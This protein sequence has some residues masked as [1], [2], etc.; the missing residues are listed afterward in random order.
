MKL[1]LGCGNKPAEGYVHHDR[2]KHSPFVDIAFDLEVLPWPVGDDSCEE[3]RAID[4][5]EHIPAWVMPIQGWLDECRRIL[6][7][8]GLLIMRLPAFDSGLLWCDPTHSRGFHH[9]SFNY[10]CPNAEGTIW[11]NFGRY[12]FGEGYNKWWLFVSCERQVNDGGDL[13]FTLRKPLSN[14]EPPRI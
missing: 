9:H 10:W 12:Y 11:Q 13:L 7:P 8:S 3:I 2:F 14:Y 6:R 5:F 4:V 1:E